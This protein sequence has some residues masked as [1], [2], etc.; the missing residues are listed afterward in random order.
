MKRISY[1]L[2]VVF[3]ICGCATGAGV[4]RSVP[5]TLE[6]VDIP[7]IGQ[8]RKAEL[9]DTIV[10]KGKLYTHQVMVLSN[11]VHSKGGAKFFVGA[12]ALIPPG[13]LLHQ[14][15]DADWEYFS[16]IS[17][18]TLTNSF[19][20]TWQSTGGLRRSKKDG[21]IEIFAPLASAVGY[22]YD[23]RPHIAPD[24]KLTKRTVTD[25]PSFQ[26]ELIYNGRVGNNIKFMYREVANDLMRPA[27][28]QEIQYDLNEGKSIGFKGARIEIIEAT[29]TNLKYRAIQSFPDAQYEK[30]D[31]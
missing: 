20:A 31:L 1:L 25:K 22:S 28:S 3:L 4:L 26:Q 7:I 27:F 13:E 29:N 30:I 8:E 12:K 17:G 14:S 24:F 15:E 10:S 6:I 23:R 11:E 5:P 18:V 16:S 21:T 2:T 9:G 19:G